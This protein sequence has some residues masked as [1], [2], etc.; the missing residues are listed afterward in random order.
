MFQF[1]KDEEWFRKWVQN[2]R[3]D[4]LRTVPIQKPCHY[5]LCSKHFEDSQFMN[6]ETKSKLIWNAIPTLFD[7]PNTPSKVTPS[8]PIKTRSIMSTMKKTS[9]KSTEQPVDILQDLPSTSKQSQVYDM[10]Q[11]KRLQWSTSTENKTLEKTAIHKAR[12]Q[13]CNSFTGGLVKIVLAYRDCELHWKTN[14]V[15]SFQKLSMQV[16]NQICLRLVLSHSM[17][18]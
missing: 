15:T 11:K 5:Q 10:P 13:S 8:H 6:K 17:N 16:C 4:D 7:V 14:N 12:K 3:W 9:A 1:P 18:F 2:S